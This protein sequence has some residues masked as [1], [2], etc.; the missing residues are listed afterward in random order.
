MDAGSAG[1][2]GDV[3][4]TIGARERLFDTDRCVDHDVAD[5]RRQ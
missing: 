1:P 3:H 5:A 2:F 4:G